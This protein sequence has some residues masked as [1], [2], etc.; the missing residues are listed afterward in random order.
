MAIYQ[1]LWIQNLYIFSACVEAERMIGEIDLWFDCTAQTA[2]S[3]EILG[4]S[5]RSKWFI[6]SKL[7]TKKIFSDT[8]QFK[9]RLARWHTFI[10]LH[11]R[12]K[13]Y[14][15]C[16]ALTQR[17]LLYFHSDEI[18]DDWKL[19]LSY[20][21]YVHV[22]RWENSSCVFLYKFALIYRTEHILM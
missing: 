10:A 20:K 2:I 8:S 19:R 9:F 13:F 1:K 16:I 22:S 18:Y 11:W 17:V 6:R 3:E 12:T 5:T 4:G 14:C 7:S 15:T 21:S